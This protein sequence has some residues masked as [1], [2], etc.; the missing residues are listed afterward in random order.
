[1]WTR[2]QFLT[3][4]AL[5]VGGVAGTA[6]GFPPQAGREPS[7]DAIR[8]IIPYLVFAMKLIWT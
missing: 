6:L 2:R 8:M 4:G 5:G 7:R 3:R 1:M